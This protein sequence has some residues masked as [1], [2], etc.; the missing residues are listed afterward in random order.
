MTHAKSEIVATMI[1]EIAHLIRL[2]FDAALRPHDLT[3]ATW[4]AVGILDRSG[5]LSQAE[6]AERLKL[7]A[8]STGRLVD[9]LEERGLVTRTAD[10][11]D[12][13]T[14]RLSVTPKAQRAL[15]RIAPVNEAICSEL[16]QDLN[17]EECA[18]LAD[19]LMRVKARLT[20]AEAAKP[21][22]GGV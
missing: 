4:Q 3:R 15:K 2:R 5:R 14:N 10:P 6:L 12:R 11:E 20:T 21:G 19:M 9:R 7:G 8:A 13:R 1:H 16:L 18:Q 22:Q 17:E